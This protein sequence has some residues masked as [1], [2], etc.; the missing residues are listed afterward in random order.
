MTS[1]PRKPLNK[2]VIAATIVWLATVGAWM[3]DALPTIIRSADLGEDY[4]GRYIESAW[5]YDVVFGAA[6]LC[7]IWLVVVGRVREG[8]RRYL[9]YTAAFPL[10]WQASVYFADRFYYPELRVKLADFGIAA[11][12]MVGLGWLIWYMELRWREHIRFSHGR[13]VA[14][15]APRGEISGG[16]VADS[17][18]EGVISDPF[19][20][21]AWYYG[22][23]NTKLHQS[24]MVFSTY[25]LLFFLA[26]LLASQLQGCEEVFDL[27]AGG[28]K[29]V[30][31]AQQVK[32]QKKVVKKLVINPYSSIIFKDRNVD[33]VKVDLKKASAHQYQLGM[34]DGDGVGMGGKNPNAKTRFIRI[35]YSGG[36]WAQDMELNPDLNLLIQYGVKTSQKIADQAE[37]MVISRLGNF[38]LGFAP[39]VVYMT[40]QKSI[41]LTKG[42]LAGL[43]EYLIDNH[44]MLF[45][46]NGGGSFHTQAFAMMRQVVPQIEPVRIPLDDVIHTTP[47][48]LPFLPYVAP[49]GGREAWGWKHEGRW[50]AYY[51]P[52]DIGD[53]WADG[54]SGVSSSVSD[55][56][57]NLGVNVLF[58]GYVENAKWRM[59]RGFQ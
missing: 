24:L 37:T 6:A 2:T 43:R 13:E 8:V 28:G 59:A 21:R 18:H 34:G 17:Y 45:L 10:L 31:K 53:A 27:P 26:C 12:F 56:C 16:L 47:F 9:L 40:G 44:G 49:H 48:E 4:A 1:A 30:Q 39:P 32:I 58:Y 7:G 3:A 14:D 22:R 20:P 29:P 52:G 36:D 50:I 25:S 42:E 15:D 33:D 51:H 5:I 35:E 55:A 23:T 57:Y 54:H 41:S 19:H 38:K 11:L 46:D